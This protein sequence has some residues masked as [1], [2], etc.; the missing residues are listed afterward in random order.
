M[1]R[2]IGTNG[3]DEFKASR[4]VLRRWQSW[5]IDGL[6]GDDILG[7]GPENDTIYGGSGNDSIQGYGGRDLIDGGSGDDDINGGSGNDTIFGGSGN[8]TINGGSDDDW[9]SGDSGN[10]SLYGF[11]GDDTLYGGTGNDT[12]DG[13]TGNDTMYGG[14]G[15]DLYFVD[16]TGDRVIEYYN[17]GFDTVYS[18]INY[19]LTDN[20]ENLILI[21]SAANAYGNSLDNRIT[22]NGANNVLSGA[23]GNDILDGGT[24]NDTM[25]GGIG[26]DLYYV[27]STGDRV[28]EYYN[29]G[30]DTVYSSINY[31]LP[32]NVENLQLT[33]SA[34]SGYGNNLDNN[35]GGSNADNFL[36]G[37]GGDDF[38][39]GGGGDDYL[40]GGVGDDL[41]WGEDGNDTLSGES[42]D[43]RMYGHAGQD[44]LIGGTGNDFLVGGLEND[45]LTGGTGRDSFV[46]GEFLWGYSARPATI[47][48]LGVDTITDFTPGIDKISLNKDS[49]FSVLRSMP[50]LEGFSNASDF[51]E[52]T[53]DAAAATSGAYIIY[54]SGNGKLF[55]NQNGASAG[56]GSGGHFATLS[57][58]PDIAASDFYIQGTLIL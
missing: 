40:F 53:S 28:I 27:D 33:G 34:Y 47:S 8:D 52:V 15:N 58:T 32:D 50:L 6:D 30:F 16:S 45:T 39:Q 13:G 1:G 3:N 57:G 31:A 22:G 10:D 21:G 43:D 19:A 56:F 41:L 9:I 35:I 37:G 54:N 23:G 36:I 5:Y 26:D 7:G 55:Y 38:I 48:D 17:Q 12:L 4:P 14:T 25:Y 20:V 2:Y 49:T 51:A 42:G 46:F 24:G 44:V 29:Q 11:T 18:S